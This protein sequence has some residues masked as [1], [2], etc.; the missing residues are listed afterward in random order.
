MSEQ[1]VGPVPLFWR[2]VRPDGEPP[3]CRECGAVCAPGLVG[4]PVCREHAARGY[5]RSARRCTSLEKQPRSLRPIEA[6]IPT[7]K[8]SG[9]STTL[10]EKLKERREAAERNG[11][12]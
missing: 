12:A 2:S 3:R 7:A 4:P 6:A 1:T 8:E 9:R 5:A 11:T 10:R